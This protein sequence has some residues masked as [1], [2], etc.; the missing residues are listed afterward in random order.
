[1]ILS[2]SL[3][4]SLLGLCLATAGC[5]VEPYAYQC[6]DKQCS[7]TDHKGQKQDRPLDEVK[8]VWERKQEREEAVR[9]N[10]ESI[11]REKAPEDGGNY[12][13]GATIRW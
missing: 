10:K 1:M 2:S 7:V 3:R 11:W 8:P 12:G 5:T 13:A 9:R 4:V 6:G